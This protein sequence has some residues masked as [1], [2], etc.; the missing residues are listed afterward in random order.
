M[1][2]TPTAMAQQAISLLRDYD[3]LSNYSRNALEFS[4]QFSWDNT[5]E[6]FQKVLNNQRN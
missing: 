4:R 1:E 6:S 2:K 5:V 3:R